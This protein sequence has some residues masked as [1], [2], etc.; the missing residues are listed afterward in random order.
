VSHRYNRPDI[1][2]RLS[3]G[4]FMLGVFATAAARRKQSFEPAPRRVTI[5]LL[6]AACALSPPVRART[7]QVGPNRSVTGPHQ[8]AELA[9]DGDRI[10][11]DPGVYQDCAIWPASRLTIETAAAPAAMRPTV[12]TQTVVTGPVCGDRGLF[13]FLGNDITVRG[14][15]FRHARSSWH[16]GAGILMEGANLTVEDSEFLDNENGILA[17]GPASSVVRL[18]HDRF[19]DNGSC[20]GACAHGVYIGKRI[21]WLDVA[22]CTFLDNHVGHH[23]KS[24]A[25][26]TVVRD[27]RIEDGP[28]GNSSYLIDLP[29]GGDAE[30]VNNVLEKGVHSENHEA[31]ISIAEEDRLN[32]T[33]VL[34]IRGNRFTNDLP[35]LTRFVRNGA[36]TPALLSANTLIG[37]VLPLDGSGSVE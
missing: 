35:E 25:R 31:A 28:D 18:R 29:D 27:S 8:A 33:H 17:G 32:P 19:Q 5:W 20:E 3:I 9:R 12:M 4:F 7:W 23:I 14:M 2:P 16:N 21:A 36:R 26:V 15:I 34:E 10:I 37:P 11:F 13:V 6:A 22:G 30:I 24:R 1:V